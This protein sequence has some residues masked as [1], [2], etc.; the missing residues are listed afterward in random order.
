MPKLSPLVDQIVKEIQNR[1][2][3]GIYQEGQMLPPEREI[4]EEFCVSRMIVRN[5]ITH[6]RER[7]AILCA[8]RCRPI[9]QKVSASRHAYDA[10]RHNIA[11]SLWHSPTNPEGHALLHG[12]HNEIDHDRYRIMLSSVVGTYWE[13]AIEAEAQFLSRASKDRDLAGII[14]WYIGGD[15]NR[16]ALEQAKEADIPIVFVDREPPKGFVA[17]YVGVDNMIAARQVVLHL[18]EQGHRKIVHISNKDNASTVQYRMNGYVNALSTLGLKPEP[19]WILREDSLDYDPS[20]WY[21]LAVQKVMNMSEQPTAVFAI[22]DRTAFWFIEACRRN[23]V[24]V[25]E[26]LCVAGFDGIERFGR[27]APFLTTANQPFERI[28][29]LAV[30]VL[31]KRIANGPDEPWRYYFL[32]A[33]LTISKSTE[34]S[35]RVNA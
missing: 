19:H 21:D 35:L 25:P 23:G 27:T 12:I 29:S 32:D 26:D 6:L 8:P 11:L 15:Q 30:E 20:A 1:I 2:K 3:S 14:I 13:E 34:A 17:D 28:G 5:A 10:G 7:G 24:R 18:I 22:N 9:V 16:W 31:L 33:P 4:A